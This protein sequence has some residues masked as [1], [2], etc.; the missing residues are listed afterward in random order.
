LEQAS[1]LINDRQSKD[2]AWFVKSSHGHNKANPTTTIN[3]SVI[4]K[5]HLSSSMCVR[6]LEQ[7]STLINDRQSKDG[8]WFV[9]SSHGHN[10][11]NPTTTITRSIIM[12]QHLSSSM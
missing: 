5:Q 4:M 7:A 1:T 9:R 8:D 11:A 6:M 2:D 3:K 12:K 10:K